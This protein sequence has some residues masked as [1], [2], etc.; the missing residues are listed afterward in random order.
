MEH[1]KQTSAA[2]EHQNTVH[3]HESYCS[4]TYT[5]LSKAPQ[6]TALEKNSFSSPLLGLYTRKE[7]YV[8]ADELQDRVQMLGN[9]NS[10]L[11]FAQ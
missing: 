1:W 3:K 10:F 5:S 11:I 9:T 2:R 7:F 6:L 4:N 8:S